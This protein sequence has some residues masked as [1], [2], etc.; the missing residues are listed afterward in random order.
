[1]QIYL[2]ELSS[3]PSWLPITRVNSHFAYNGRLMG[4]SCSTGT[5]GF[6]GDVN[7]QHKVSVAIGLFRGEYC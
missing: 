7:K 4:S 3:L 2:H 5:A 1:M 6:H